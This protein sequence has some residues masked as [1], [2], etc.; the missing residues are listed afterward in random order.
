MAR[1]FAFLLTRHFTLS[2]FALFVDTLRL[3]GDEDDRSRRVEFDWQVVG[4]RGLPI[5]ASCGIEVMPTRELQHPEEYDDIV[6]VGG[7]L[8]TGDTLGSQKEA[9]LLKAASRGVRLTALCTA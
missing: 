8:N 6:V 4:E 3:A 5:R 9:F 7:L 2:P 1:K